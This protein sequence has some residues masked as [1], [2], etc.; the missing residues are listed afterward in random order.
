MINVCCVWLKGGIGVVLGAKV[1]PLTLGLPSDYHCTSEDELLSCTR[2]LVHQSQVVPRS[3]FCVLPC[4]NTGHWM[5]TKHHMMG[6]SD[7]SQDLV[8]LTGVLGTLL[9]FSGPNGVQ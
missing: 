2:C 1:L 3:V 9:V 4:G 6:P 8:A 5:R 7:V